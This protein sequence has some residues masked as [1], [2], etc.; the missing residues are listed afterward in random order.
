MN[1]A[2]A[3]KELDTSK[4][5][6]YA[7]MRKDASICFRLF[8]ICSLVGYKWSLSLL[9]ICWNIF[10]NI[11]PGVFTKW[12]DRILVFPTFTTRALMRLAKKKEETS[13]G[14]FLVRTRQWYT[15]GMRQLRLGASGSR[16]PFGISFVCCLRLGCPS[17]P[18]QKA[19][20]SSKRHKGPQQ[21]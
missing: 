16:G 14:R 20:W 19:T 5:A 11:C 18:P 21:G 12:K 2:M 8:F 15:D 4:G 13:N 17:T 1:P 10:S 6:I 3:Q 7:N 9:E